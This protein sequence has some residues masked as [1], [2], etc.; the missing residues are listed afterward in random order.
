VGRYDAEVGDAAEVADVDDVDEVQDADDVE[1]A[2]APKEIE[3]Y[4]AVAR[5]QVPPKAITS[6]RAVVA[7]AYLEPEGEQKSDAV[8][9][10]E[11]GPPIPGQRIV[12]RAVVAGTEEW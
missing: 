2:P 11:V 10:V 4:T 12:G 5:A 3:Q 9:P 7:S 8:T 6:G 1:P